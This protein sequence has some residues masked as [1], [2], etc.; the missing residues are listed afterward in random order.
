MQRRD[1]AFNLATPR[2][3]EALLVRSEG[4]S[5][6]SI[7]GVGT[8]RSLG[9][10]GLE[11]LAWKTYKLLLLAITAVSILEFLTTTKKK[12]HVS[13]CTDYCL[14]LE[15]AYVSRFL[16]DDGEEW[17]RESNEID[18]KLEYWAEFLQAFADAMGRADLREQ[19]SGRI[20]PDVPMAMELYN[21]RR[22]G[23]ED[24]RKLHQ[25]RELQKAREL[26]ELWELKQALEQEK[27]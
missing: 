12:C 27:Y 23:L 20:D 9:F 16:D 21:R 26:E 1:I 8:S 19:D 6:G 11:Q 3:S 25:A 22:A 5:I 4:T 18:E 15:L 13:L 24:A 10:K 7:L 17:L 14:L 2:T